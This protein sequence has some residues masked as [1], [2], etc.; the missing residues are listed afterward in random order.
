VHK[1][2]SPWF[3]LVGATTVAVLALYLCGDWSRAK[4]A[5]QAAK[6]AKE[7]KDAKDA[8]PPAAAGVAVTPSKVTAV[9]VYPLNALVT[10]EAEVPPGK[11]PVEL[12][13]SPLPQA[14]VLSSLNGEGSEG[15]RVLSTRFRP[16]TVT[17]DNREAIA[18]LQDETDQLTTAREK[19]DAD[20]RAVQ[21]NLKM[22]SKLENILPMSP[23]PITLVKYI[24]EDRIEITRGQVKLEQ[25]I[26]TNQGKAN[27]LKGQMS[28]LAGATRTERDAVIV[29]DRGEVN[30]AGKVRLSYLVDQATWRPQYKLRAGKVA[31]DPV[32]VEFLAAVMQNSGED[33]GNVKLVLSTAQPMLYASAPDL[34]MLRVG[35]VHKSSVATRPPDVAE[36]EDQVKSLRTKAQKDFNEKKQHTGSGLFNTAASL[37]QA[38]ELLNPD[39]AIQR[40]CALAVREGPTVTYRVSSALNVPSRADEQVVEVARAELTYIGSD[41]VGQMTLPL[42]AAGEQ[43]TVGFGID[44]QLHVTR[45]IVNKANTT[46]G[47]NQTLRYE[48]RTSVNNFKNEAVKLQVWDRLPRP[49]NDA[50]TVSMIKVTPDLSKDAA[51]LRGPRTQNLLRWD[52]TVEPNSTGEKAVNIQYEFKMELDKNMTISDLQSAGTSGSGATAHA[53]LPP[54]TPAEQAKINAAMARLNP[55]DQAA[56]R[57]QV[58]CAIDQDSRLGSMGPIQK[59]MVKNQPVFLCCKGCEAEARAHPDD[60]LVKLQNLL[61]RLNKRP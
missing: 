24:K 61:N 41:F 40:G 53:D 55:A 59:I 26:K 23:D 39:T 20:L 30:T 10:R 58:F 46:Q 11:G 6:E 44:P 15:I 50:V 21:E 33:W 35:A 42:I 57:A 17:I 4:L 49:E 52:L 60:T 18:R 19:L 32:Q 48:Y 34:Q 9:T 12:T 1:R 38:F 16:R 36:L 5:A 3:T 29:V 56:A 2:F 31:K 43:F 47:G 37:D 54:I 27:V 28:E 45:Q 7:A 8:A 22:L 13:I 14:A 51:Y 25:D